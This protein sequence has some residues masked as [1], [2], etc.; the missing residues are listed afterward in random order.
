MIRIILVLAQALVI[1]GCSYIK[2]IEVDG[3]ELAP[4]YLEGHLRSTKGLLYSFN[5]ENGVRGF[6]ESC[7]SAYI[8]FIFYK[9]GIALHE[10]IS[11]VAA[12]VGSSLM[13][14]WPGNS[15]TYSDYDSERYFS[16]LLSLGRSIVN[17]DQSIDIWS[18][19]T[20]L[21]IVTV[22]V[23]QSGLVTYATDPIEYSKAEVLDTFSDEA[24]FKVISPKT[25]GGPRI[26]EVL[27]NE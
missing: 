19:Y 7:D 9:D 18:D 21:V 26:L 12:L 22:F 24:L 20:E 17:S 23:S 2:P 8:K 1:S 3:Y 27:Q 14:S 10:N 5:I 16:T 13:V 15:E 25:R 11:T 6:C 4:V